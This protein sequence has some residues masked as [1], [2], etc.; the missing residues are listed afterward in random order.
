M[1]V[2]AAPANSFPMTLTP[3][4]NGVTTAF[5]MAISGVS[6][7][8]PTIAIFRN[9]LLQAPTTDY[10]LVGSAITF[11]VAPDVTDTFRVVT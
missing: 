7:I 5:T 2:F 4:P 10:S 8:S 1:P 6:V 9:G 11:V 3:T